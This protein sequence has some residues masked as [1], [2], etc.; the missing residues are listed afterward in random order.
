MSCTHPL[1]LAASLSATRHS[2]PAVQRSLDRL[3]CL[4]AV[5]RYGQSEY[6]STAAASSS[7]IG[8]GAAAWRELW[9]VRKRGASLLMPPAASYSVV[10][11]GPG[12]GGG[13]ADQPWRLI[14]YSK[15]G[16]HL[17][18]GL[19]EKLE[20]LLERAEFLPSVLRCTADRLCCAM[21]QTLH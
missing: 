15:E 21:H 13:S 4:N 11:G 14:I 6:S 16:C 18:D 1:R 9:E 8:G 5:A 20:A 12:G 17:C 7:N 3:P 10:T 2:F 19:K